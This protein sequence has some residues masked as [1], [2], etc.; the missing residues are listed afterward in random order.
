MIT[1]L[2]G[3]VAEGIKGTQKRFGPGSVVIDQV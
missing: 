1:C 2:K 3:Q